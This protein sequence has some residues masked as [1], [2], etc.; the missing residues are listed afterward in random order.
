MRAFIFIALVALTFVGCG[1]KTGDLLRDDS[2][3]AVVNVK[4]NDPE[5]VLAIEKARATLD[6]FLAKMKDPK[7]AEADFAIKA[8]LPATGA[9]DV[10]HIWVGSLEQVGAKFKGKLLNEPFGMPGK[11]IGSPVEFTR[12]QVSDWMIQKS[13]GTME[14]AFTQKVLEELAKKR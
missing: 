10:E 9:T 1:P 8:G 11:K 13:D 12:D 4:S 14:G 6:E 5:M 3:G 7:Y 2:D